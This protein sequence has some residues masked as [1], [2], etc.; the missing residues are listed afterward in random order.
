MRLRSFHGRTI[1]DVMRQIRE[2]M[3][4]DAIIVATR[5]EE[6]GGV[7][8]TAALDDAL[9]APTMDTAKHPPSG[10]SAPPA[11]QDIIGEIENALYQHGIP[12][13]LAEQI[14]QAS[15]R[16][17][18]HDPLLTLAAALDQT[19]PTAPLTRQQKPILLIGPPGS[20]KTLTAAKIALQA[21]NLSKKII[22]F[23]TDTLRAAGMAELQAFTKLL[24]LEL[25]EIEDVGA[26]ADAVST[27]Q[28]GQILIDSGGRNPFNMDD[29]RELAQLIQAAKAEPVLVMPAGLD[30]VEAA[31]IARAYAA[32]GANRMILTRL[33]LV[34]RLGSALGTAHAAGLRLA[35]LCG[36]AKVADGI[37]P[38][39]PVAVARR[40]LPDAQSE[41]GSKD[42]SS[43]SPTATAPS[44]TSLASGRLRA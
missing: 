21:Q 34:R 27:H 11:R 35:G 29:M 22:V 39:D 40:I 30:G 20:G 14:V 4:E 19:L 7:R 38:F 36:S 23:S 12:A 42:S 44:A 16:H 33:D 43:T 3:G 31:D 8:V 10:I 6:G 13:A 28:E 15:A 25:V 2:T 1:P 32:L 24:G 17:L 9:L 37:T 18:S 41:A 26:L 5:E